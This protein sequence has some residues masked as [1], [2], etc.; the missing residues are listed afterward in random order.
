MRSDEPGRVLVVDEDY[1]TLDVLA[2]TL[3]MMG[4]RV[5]LATDGQSGLKHAVDMAAEV[6]LVDRDVRV[7]DIRTFLDVLT[8][9]P[10]TAD[11]HVFVL[12]RDDPSE[13]AALHGRAEPIVKPFHA[14][15]VAA[16]VMEVIRARREPPKGPEL[17]GDLQQVALFDLLQVFAANQR[18]GQLVVESA[19]L[20][21]EVWVV[22]G[23]V[24]DAS[25]GLVSGEKALFR[26]L[27]LN[28]GQFVF[29]P[30]R[31]PLRQR[32]DAPTEH[33][34]MEAV[35][36]VDERAELARGL[37]A[38]GSPLRLAF[39]PD[40]KA[41]EDL[42]LP[43]VVRDVLGHLDEARTV[44][45]LLDLAS[46]HD[47]DVLR[48]LRRLVELEALRSND[49]A[50]QV[51]LCA[52]EEVPLFRAAAHRLRRPGVEGPVRLGVAGSAKAVRH[53][54]RALGGIEEFV[55]A[56]KP[57]VAIGSGVFGPLGHL[58]LGGT[59]LELFALPTDED[60]RPWWGAFLAASRV[61]L[62]LGE[63]VEHEDLR[64]A[65]AGDEFQRPQ[66]AAEA[67]REAIGPTR[68][69]G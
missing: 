66:N 38:A 67:L 61:V 33:L 8:D 17:E 15:E 65:Y 32:I 56:T 47:L 14:E 58:A 39:Q 63:D 10:R 64:V 3:R 2:R 35:R 53:F 1:D 37:P 7:F 27:A 41:T 40:E 6:V 68:R 18:T 5:S 52:D 26:V 36:H 23:R 60:L 30:D 29:H 44:S 19:T 4:A 49:A 20:R 57:P 43:E 55:V 22:D 25:S 34:L 42:R 45:E 48:V 9:N 28:Q 16:R 46:A 62:V 13:L 11:A 51:R 59:D 50:G 12:G 69:H 31:R 21:G 24:V 54:G